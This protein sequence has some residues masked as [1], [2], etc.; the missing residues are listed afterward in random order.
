M[1][2]GQSEVLTPSDSERWTITGRRHRMLT[3]QWQEDAMD[4]EAEFYDPS[5]RD[6]LPSPEISSNVF[7]S[8]AG[9]I[10]TLYSETVSATVPDGYRQEDVEQI[11]TWRWRPLMARRHYRT[12][13]LNECFIRLDFLEGKVCYRIVTPDMV[14]R[15][16]AHPSDPERAI[17]LWEYRPRVDEVTGVQHD[18]WE[19]WL[20][21]TNG[22]PV[23]RIWEFDE[24]NV[25]TDVTARWWKKRP[26]EGDFPYTDSAD[27][28]IFPYILYHRDVS[29]ELFSPTFGGEVVCGTL[30]IAAMT[31]MWIGQVRDNASPKTFAKDCTVQ[32][33]RTT[34][35]GSGTVI[36]SGSTVIQVRTNNGATSSE[37]GQLPAGADPKGSL[38][39]IE[40]FEARVAQF[41]GVPPSDLIR[42]STGQS[43]YAVVVKREGLRVSQRAQ[44]PCATAGDQL[45][46]ATA[47][48]MTNAYAGTLLPEDPEEW[49]LAYTEISRTPEEVAADLDIIE[50]KLDLGMMSP[51]DAMMAANPGM[52]E[53]EALEKLAEIAKIKAMLAD[54]GK[55]KTPPAPPAQPAEEVEDE[56][57]E[58]PS[59]PEMA[60][61]MQEEE[62]G[63]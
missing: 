43:G 10:N 20:V 23:F 25:R 2:T 12:L 47:A 22:E 30:T 62:E 59:T 45:T 60:G 52:D 38:E 33:T 34:P 31:T 35:E 3:S 28:P 61:E 63:T 18:T 53:D 42:G 19:E 8:V 55:P 41:A 9:Q 14:A 16:V 15:V 13:G 57:E 50:R 58:E 36:A 37:F 7:A 56:D 4:R 40:L 46:C 17:G 6:Q 39:A 27:A 54:V 11:L 5:I 26:D 32:T 48:R 44:I 21:P 29:G 51:V 1:P 24:K 49:T